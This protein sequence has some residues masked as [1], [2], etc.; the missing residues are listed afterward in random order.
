MAEIVTEINETNSLQVYVNAVSAAKVWSTTIEWTTAPQRWSRMTSLVKTIYNEISKEPYAIDS[1][2][3]LHEVKRVFV[4][5]KPKKC[6][7]LLSDAYYLILSVKKA[8]AN[9]NADEINAKMIGAVIPDGFF[10]NLFVTSKP[11]LDENSIKTALAELQEQLEH[12]KLSRPIDSSGPTDSASSKECEDQTREIQRGE[13]A[14]YGSQNP[15]ELIR[16]VS[17]GKQE[18]PVQSTPQEKPEALAA[19]NMLDAAITFKELE[20]LCEEIHESQEKILE[21]IQKLQREYITGNAPEW[22]ITLPD[23]IV[24][25]FVLRFAKEYI[26]LWNGITENYNWHAKKASKSGNSD[27]QMAVKNYL[28][29]RRLIQY[30][31]SSFGVE[32][33]A[34]K[35]GTP[36]NGNIHEPVGSF[37]FSNPVV[38]KSL[39]DCFYYKNR[40]MD[41]AIVIQKELVRVKSGDLSDLGGANEIRN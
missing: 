4:E 22:V 37:A 8:V 12:Q 9:G 11:D 30:A 13:E 17:Q 35:P 14:L 18:N 19:P 38:D 23:K 15:N 32:M 31:L 25:S 27:Y 39:R 16:S 6:N 36:L 26:K 29:Y 33:F 34:S 41:R 40:S 20:K 21:D 2:S 28:D 3:F 24:E 10:N 7:I 5:N 1:S